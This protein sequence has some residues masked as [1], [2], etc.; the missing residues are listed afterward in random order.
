MSIE[1]VDRDLGPGVLRD[2]GV[3]ADVVPVAVRG[4]DVFQGPVAGREL[5]G[6]P[7]EAGQGGVDGDRLAGPV[8]GEDV[9]VGREDADDAVELGQ[10]E[11]SSLA[12]M[13]SKAWP[14]S[15]FA[16]PSMR[17]EPTLATVPMI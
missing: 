3:V 4:D 6:D 13:Q 17:R 16:V 10:D 7:L 9:E 14:I 8:V 12:R 15:L 11:A 1:R 5:L 2:P